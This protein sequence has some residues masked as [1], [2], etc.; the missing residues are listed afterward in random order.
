V[1]PTK[2]SWSTVI[3]L[4]GK[5][6]MTQIAA[7]LSERE[8]RRYTRNFVSSV[9]HR[10]RKRGMITEPADPK[11]QHRLGRRNYG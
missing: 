6:S 7:V 1:T 2:P 5:K 4:H 10:A 3:E 11:H 8:G 9:I